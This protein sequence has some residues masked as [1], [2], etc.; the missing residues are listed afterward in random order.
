[1][2]WLIKQIKSQPKVHLEDKM[3]LDLGT[4]DG[5]NQ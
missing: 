3:A 2:R 5:Q 1:M 4:G